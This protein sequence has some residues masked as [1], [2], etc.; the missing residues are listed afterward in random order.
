MPIK[1]VEKRREYQREYMRRWYQENKATHIAYVRSRES[2][3]KAWLRDYKQSIG[4]E[5]CGE[6]HPACLEFHHTDPSEKKFSIGR[7]RDYL[8]VRLLK[9]E[10]AKC[11]LLCAN[12][13]RKRHWKEPAAA[14][15]SKARRQQRIW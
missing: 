12:C 4:C 1:D 3:I 6:T 7:V 2:R 9:T 13:H 15:P 5:D 14:Q 8:S 10:I 11:R